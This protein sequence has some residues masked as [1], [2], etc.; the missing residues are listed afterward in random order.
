MGLLKSLFR[1]LATVVLVL[2]Y[3]LFLPLMI[4]ARMG[5]A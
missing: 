5:K 3:V 2:A 1:I 4:I